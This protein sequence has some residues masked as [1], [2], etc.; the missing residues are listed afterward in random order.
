MGE[1]PGG[2]LLYLYGRSFRTGH[3]RFGS[4]APGA[5]SLDTDVLQNHGSLLCESTQRHC[6]HSLRRGVPLFGG[7]RVDQLSLSLSQANIE[8]VKRGDELSSPFLSNSC[9]S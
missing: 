1:T 8:P 6:G 4:T 9:H 7:E 5:S 3:K 2:S